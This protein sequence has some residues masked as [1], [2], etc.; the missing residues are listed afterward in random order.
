MRRWRV[1]SAATA[2]AVAEERS[3]GW[4][5]WRDN[6]EGLGGWNYVNRLSLTTLQVTGMGFFGLYGSTFAL[7][8]TLTLATVVNCVGIGFQRGAHNNW[9]LVKNDGTG[10]P[11]LTDLRASFPVSSTSNVLTLTIAAAPN[12]ADI[13]VRVVEEVSGEVVEFTIV[14]TDM[15]TATQLLSPRNY[16]N[17]GA[18]AAAV[19]Y[20]CSGVDVETD[21]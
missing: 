18:A 4:V 13:G 2:D 12:G 5:F 17:N 16:M 14:A 11:T 15:P 8:T 21:Y 1:T 9:Q 20:D 19:A 10:A 3:A 7:T 6:A